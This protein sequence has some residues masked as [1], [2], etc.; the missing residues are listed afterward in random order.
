MSHI[1][2]FPVVIS[3]SKK[4]ALE[5]ADR[6]NIPDRQKMSL[7]KLAPAIENAPNLDINEL[8][9]W[10]STNE[11]QEAY[12]QATGENIN[13]TS[14]TKLVRLLHQALD[15]YESSADEGFGEWESLDNLDYSEPVLIPTKRFDAE[16]ALKNKDRQYWL[17]VTR[18]E[19]YADEFGN[20]REDLEPGYGEDISGWWTCHK[21]TK[22]GDLIL[23]WRT[24]PKS[25]IGYLIVALSDAYS[26]NSDPY[27]RTQSWDYGCEYQPLYKFES[28]ITVKDLK[29]NPSYDDWRPKRGRFQRSV[30]KID[31]EYWHQLTSD[32][33]MYNPGYASFLAGV[34]ANSIIKKV[35]LEVEIEDFLEANLGCLKQHGYD[36]EL[37]VDPD[38]KNNGRQVYCSGINGRIDL[39][40]KRKDREGWVVI[41]LKNVRAGQNTY[42]QIATYV[43]WITNHVANGEPVDG[44]V[45]SRGFDA[46]FEFSLSM[47]EKVKQLNLIDIGIE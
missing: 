19:Y 11:L 9:D 28:P 36:L 23:L 16:S 4:R 37:W 24:S 40:C 43:G 3:L 15:D 26:I 14:K 29:E 12:F 42:G 32:L 1:K 20:D 25:D 8:T 41:E 27:A 22:A 21:D 45:I 30:F 13:E 5:F 18:K 31:D 33:D 7:Q 6:L 34:T 47:S 10:L 35:A 38:T 2:A 44:L 17:W 39:L 46:K